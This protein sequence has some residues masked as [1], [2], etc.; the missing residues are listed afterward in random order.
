MSP[1]FAWSASLLV[2][3]M[4]VLLSETLLRFREAERVSQREA[5][6]MGFASELR[7]RVDRELNSVLYLSSGI[8]G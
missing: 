6:T 4:A 2:F 8:V 1:R 5:A 3:A 7:A